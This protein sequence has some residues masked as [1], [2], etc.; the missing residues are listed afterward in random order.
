ML[1]SDLNLTTDPTQLTVSAPCLSSGN[2]R[3]PRVPKIST[4]QNKNYSCIQSV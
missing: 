2:L 3:L 1:N 4:I